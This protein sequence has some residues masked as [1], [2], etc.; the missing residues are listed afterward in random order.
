[1]KKV[2]IRVGKGTYGKYDDTY[3]AL[4]LANSLITMENFVVVYLENDGVYAAVK[5]QNP[6]YIGA[7]SFVKE[8]SQVLWMGAILCVDEDSIKKRKI[9]K[10][11]LIDGVKIVGMNEIMEMAGE[12]DFWIGI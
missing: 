9:E 6:H 12:F 1:M 7:E 5:S 3:N 10:E 4:R 11:E 2:I 8:L